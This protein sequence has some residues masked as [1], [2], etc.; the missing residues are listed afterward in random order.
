M[1]NIYIDAYF[2]FELIIL[3]FLHIFVLPDVA[4][5]VVSAVVLSFIKFFICDVPSSCTPI[6]LY[7]IVLQILFQFFS[8]IRCISMTCIDI[9]ICIFIC[10][11]DIVIYIF[12][13][14][15]NL[16]HISHVIFVYKCI[17]YKVF[18]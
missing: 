13:I 3:N 1:F 2:S 9:S 5:S 17:V 4:F 18:K 6:F 8:D 7:H 14:F 16:L 11:N 15:F 10:E 12:N